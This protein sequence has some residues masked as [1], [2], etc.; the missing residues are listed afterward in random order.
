MT[1]CMNALDLSEETCAAGTE[2][3]SAIATRD[4]VLI[5]RMM[6]AIHDAFLQRCRDCANEIT[7]DAPSADTAARIVLLQASLAK[8]KE[9]CPYRIGTA[10]AEA[11]LT[12]AEETNEFACKAIGA[13]T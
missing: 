12:A 9:A 6:L 10:R 13:K 5:G 11:W 2:I 1:L 4:E 8:A 3:L 7:S